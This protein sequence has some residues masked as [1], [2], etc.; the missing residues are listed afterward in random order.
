MSRR[1]VSLICSVASRVI[2]F[3][4]AIVAALIQGV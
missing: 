1:K 3:V 4:A 2:M